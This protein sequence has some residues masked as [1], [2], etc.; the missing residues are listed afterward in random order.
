M[1]LRTATKEEVDHLSRRPLG[2]FTQTRIGAMPRVRRVRI[3][4][5]GGRDVYL[6]SV[7]APDS[8]SGSHTN[9]TF[10]HF[11]AGAVQLPHRVEGRV[12]MLRRGILRTPRTPGL[13]EV[14]EGLSAGVL[15][16]YHVYASDPELAA[17]LLDGALADWL[18]AEGHGA[19]YE[20]VHDLAVAYK[21]RNFMVTPRSSLLGRARAIAERIPAPPPS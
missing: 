21:G 7:T 9:A 6:F 13:S 14:K 2:L 12:G 16:D 4:E 18:V 20:I 3:G 17:T 19:C 11:I 5:E 8:R 15:D 1:A 10:D